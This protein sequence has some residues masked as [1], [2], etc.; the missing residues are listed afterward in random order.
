MAVSKKVLDGTTQSEFT[1]GRDSDEVGIRSNAGIIQLRNNSGGYYTPSGGGSA[2][3]R[4]IFTV[5][6]ADIINGYLD[7]SAVPVADSELVVV[8]GIIQYPGGSYQYTISGNRVTFLFTL[9]LSDPVMV[10]YQV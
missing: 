8:N 10:K 2:W 3:L 5:S 9:T 7:L 1:I 4:D 6:P